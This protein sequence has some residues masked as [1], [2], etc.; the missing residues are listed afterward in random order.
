MPRVGPYVPTGGV[1]YTTLGRVTRIWPVRAP[2]RPPPDPTLSVSDETPTRVR[3]SLDLL[4]LTGLLLI[5]VLIAGLGTVAT[6]TI[7]G[8]NADLTRLLNEVPRLFVRALSLLGAI[9]ALALPV[10][11][12]IRDIVRG[13][14]RRLVEGL[15]TGLLAI[16]VVGLLDLAIEAASGSALHGVLSSVATSTTVRPL[17]GYLAA[18]FALVVVVGLDD[19]PV[20]RTAFWV[21]IGVYVVS[22]FAAAQASPLSLVA[23]P[24]IGAA[25]GLAVRY[26]VGTADERPD[27]RRVAAVLRTRG[28]DVVRIERADE[29]GE[30]YRN[31][32]VTTAAGQRLAVEVFDRDLITSGAAYSVWRRVR[33]RSALS[34]APVLSL[35]RVAE[36][37]AVLAYA[38]MAAGVRVPR[39]VAGV[40]CGP[41]AVVLVYEDV[42]ARRLE[43][44][45]D[46]QLGQLWGCVGQLHRAGITHRGLSAER[47]LVDGTG[48]VV[49]PILTAGTLFASP[50]RISLD[51][52]QVLMTTAQLV[53]AE[54]AV[55][56]ARAELTQAELAATLPLLQPVALSR[57]TRAAL[58]KDGD[59]LESVRDQIHDQTEQ[60]LPE[61]IR[62]ERVRPRTVLSIV[63]LLIAGYLIVGQLGSVDLATVFSTARWGWV[64]LV[65]VASAGTYFAAALS[66]TGF[67]TERLRYAWTVLVQVASSFVGFVTPPSVGGLALNI[68]YLRAAKLSAAGAA[69]SVGTSQVINAVMHAVLLVVFAAATGTSTHDSLPIPGWAFIAV[70]AIAVVALLALAVPGPR[71]WTLARV[72]PPLQEAAPRLLSLASSPVKLTEALS[73]TLLLNACYIAA[74]WFSVLAFAGG[75]SVAGVAVVYLAG[76]AVASAAPTPGGLGAVEVAL[77]TGLTAA[78]MSGTAAISAVLLFRLSTFWLPVPAGWLALQYLQRRDVV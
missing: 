4:R 52:A 24:A 18:L 40:P 20:W 33:I 77:S 56:V 15:A 78:G 9:G 21:V 63:A 3:R 14:G 43:D 53:G 60:D 16:A 5:V 44:P 19:D 13:R 25:V 6:D 58:K 22:A 36:R 72:L 27:A 11:L 51:R 54:R 12:V 61:P 75:V 66:L 70:G 1:G 65:L 30:R 37:R 17:D 34:A 31:Y 41:D 64:P 7:A 46:D 62:V 76:A 26:S 49:L 2:V 8:L 50:L 73:G 32:A 69:T 47:V 29:P 28:I 55:R 59:L 68:R 35:E 38:A 48:Q 74:L 42:G 23:S 45:T 67:V 71:K 10:A 39:F 57:E